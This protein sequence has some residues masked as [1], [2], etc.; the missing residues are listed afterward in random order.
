MG[1]RVVGGCSRLTYMVL[2]KV[3]SDRHTDRSG[4]SGLQLHAFEI[5]RT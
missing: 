1:G 5:M 4:G 3:E 2:D